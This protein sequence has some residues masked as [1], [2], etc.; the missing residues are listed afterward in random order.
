VVHKKDTPKLP[1]I[2]AGLDIDRPFADKPQEKQNIAD[3]LEDE[4]PIAAAAAAQ[5]LIKVGS[6]YE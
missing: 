6:V 3:D 4:S 5:K 1:D 2:I